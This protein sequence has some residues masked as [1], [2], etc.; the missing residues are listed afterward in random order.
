[1]RTIA[2]NGGRIGKPI[3]NILLQRRDGRKGGG[4]KTPDNKADIIFKQS[5]NGRGFHKKN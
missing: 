1:M 4:I 2:G 5:F 3:A